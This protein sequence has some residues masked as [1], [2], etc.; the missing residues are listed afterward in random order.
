MAR[1]CPND[2]GTGGG[3]RRPPREGGEP[4]L[5]DKPRERYDPIALLE[6]EAAFSER[7]ETHSGTGINFD[8]YDK[9]PVQVITFILI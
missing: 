3:S 6:G 9:I 1:D 4:G 2:D 7:N 8:H 5:D